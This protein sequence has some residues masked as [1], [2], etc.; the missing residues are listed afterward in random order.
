LILFFKILSSFVILTFSVRTFFGFGALTFTST[1]SSDDSSSTCISF[2][3]LTF[4]GFSS[5]PD[6][7]VGAGVASC[8][9]FLVFFLGSTFSLE[10]SASF[11]AFLASRFSLARAFFSAAASAA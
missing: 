4:F 7:D 2:L 8:S 10:T 6:S 11:A 9:T 5:F 1:S 3:R